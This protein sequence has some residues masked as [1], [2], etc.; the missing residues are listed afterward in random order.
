MADALQ[1]G[2]CI[3][4]WCRIIFTYVGGI[5]LCGCGNNIINA[6]LLG[7]DR[8]CIVGRGNRLGNRLLRL[9]GGR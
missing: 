4:F 6:G 7:S 1:R 8:T 9:G 3:T 5:G 2:A